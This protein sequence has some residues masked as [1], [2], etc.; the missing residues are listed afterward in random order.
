M[1]SDWAIGTCYYYLQT[2]QTIMRRLPVDVEKYMTYV[3]DIRKEIGLLRKW[4]KSD[5][6]FKEI[7]KKKQIEQEVQRQL[8]IEAKVKE[9]KEKIL[10]Q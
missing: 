3:D 6:R 7:I 1:E 8:E 9:E 2:F 5:N 4:K 10:A